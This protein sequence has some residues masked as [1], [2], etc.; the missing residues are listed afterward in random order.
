MLS[1]TA[2]S[3]IIVWIGALFFSVTLGGWIHLLPVAALPLF[4][5]SLRKGDMPSAD[6]SRWKLAFA[7]RTR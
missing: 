6:Y 1:M 3:L 2:V 4:I 5:A 7:R